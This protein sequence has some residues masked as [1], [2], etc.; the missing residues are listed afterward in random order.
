VEDL[1]GDRYADVVAVHPD[2]AAPG[3]PFAQFPAPLQGITTPRPRGRTTRHTAS[4]RAHHPPPRVREGAPPVPP[5]AWR[6]HHPPP[7]PPWGV[8]HPRP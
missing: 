3:P 4:E 6:A 2:R 7:A 1:V 5:G 8:Y